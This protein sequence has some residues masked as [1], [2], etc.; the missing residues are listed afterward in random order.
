MKHIIAATAILLATSSVMADVEVTQPSNTQIV[1]TP[2]AC[3]GK[4]LCNVFHI[5]YVTNDGIVAF[6]RD[7]P[8]AW[9][10]SS[11]SIEVRTPKGVVR[12][13]SDR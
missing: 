12:V 9:M 5:R 13:W 6:L 8:S 7:F 4:E 2:V 11:T 1:F 3:P 10:A